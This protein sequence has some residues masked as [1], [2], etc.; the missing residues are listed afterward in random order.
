MK[1]PKVKEARS[2]WAVKAAKRLANPKARDVVTVT[3]AVAFIVD[4]LAPGP[5]YRR[6]E[7]NKV[8]KRVR[9]ALQRGELRQVATDKMLFGDLTTWGRGYS[10]WRD[11]LAPFPSLNPGAG[12]IG[13]AAMQAGGRGSAMPS[14]AAELQAALR[15]AHKRICELEDEI[16]AKDEEL[17]RLRPLEVKAQKKVSDG[18]LYG[19]MGG[20]P[21]K[22]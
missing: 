17:T 2:P 14:D 5:D 13:F 16:S 12:S 20:R 8:R 9:A 15:A 4:Q 6:L 21:R 18:K 19:A 7:G 11:A 10:D 3:E 22:R 1:D